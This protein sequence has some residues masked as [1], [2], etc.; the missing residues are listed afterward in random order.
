[1]GRQPS[2]PRLGTPGPDQGYALRLIAR[3]RDRIRIQAGE[4]I[5]DAVRG[6]VGIAMR[7]AAT[8]GRAP[9]IDDV[10]CALT[11]WG[12]LLDELPAD[13]AE[14]RLESFAGIGLGS[15]HYA[16]ARAVVDSIPEQTLRMTLAQLTAAMPGSWRAVTGNV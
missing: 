11:M 8:F 16:E 13:L 3:V 5:D 14:C 15:H 10:L 12:W 2:G 6:S 4:S 1:M 7:R 9:V